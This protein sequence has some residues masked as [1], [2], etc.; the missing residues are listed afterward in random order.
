MGSVSPSA[1]NPAKKVFAQ[2]DILIIAAL[3]SEEVGNYSYAVKLFRT[4]YEKSGK[5]E[6]LYKMLEDLMIQRAYSD[7]IQEVDYYLKN[8]S[9]PFLYP[10]SKYFTAVLYFPSFT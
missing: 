6:Y 10:L 4:L 3:R 8:G 7:V 1:P 5:K 2:E 9:Y